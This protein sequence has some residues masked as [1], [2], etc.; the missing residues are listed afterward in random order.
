MIIRKEDLDSAAKKVLAQLRP[1]D[2][3]ALSGS[4]AAGKTT[5]TQAL[6]KAMGY[7]G[8]V[9]SPTFVLE[10]RYPVKWRGADEVVHLDFY[11]LDEEQAL[12][13]D[14]QDHLTSPKQL[15]IIE[16]PERVHQH[17]PPAT[18]TIV[19]EVIDEQTR[20]LALSSNFSD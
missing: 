15:T 19:F 18:K 16:W 4:L 5:F 11:R 20:R 6:L 14:W 2:V 9:R 3:L 7:E 12:S 13:F 17:L 8:R 1:G 10:H